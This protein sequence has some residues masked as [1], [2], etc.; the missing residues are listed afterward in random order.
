MR[1]IYADSGLLSN[2]GHHAP[3]C[4]TILRELHA[5]GVQTVL[6]AGATIDSDLREELAAFPLFRISSYH[7]TTGDPLCGWFDGFLRGTQQTAEDYSRLS[8]TTRDDILYV[9]GVQPAHLAGLIEWLGKLP[10]ERMPAVVVDLIFPP[11]MDPKPGSNNEV[12]ES[13]DPREDG[14]AV[15]YRH[16]G[17]RLKEMNLTRLRFVTEYPDLPKIYGILLLRDIAYTP[18]LPLALPANLRRRAGVRPMTVGIVGHQR[19]DKGYAFMPEVFGAPLKARDDIRILVHNSGPMKFRLP[20]T[21]RA[22][23]DLAARDPRLALR[24]EALS[25]DQ[26]E[27]VLA[28]IDLML[29]P[30]DPKIYRTALSGVVMEC[31]IRAIPVVVPGGTVNADQFRIFGPSGVAFERFDAASITAAALKALDH[32]DDHAAAAVTT[33]HTWAR[34][35]DPGKFVD[36]ILRLGA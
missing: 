34:D 19:P 22:L 21:D 3:V 5:R 32:F 26:Y 11:G 35:R 4:R 20:E 33:A 29:C 16:I 9:T 31:L 2:T 15:F 6:L 30:Y 10:P 1:L 27:A 25:P 18:A 8:D 23:A 24:D 14:R 12:W 7:F 13:R 36:E 17:L 28:S